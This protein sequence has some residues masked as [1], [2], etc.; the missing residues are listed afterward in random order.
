[1]KDLILTLKKTVPKHT[2][3]EKFNWC[4][5]DWLPYSSDFKRIRDKMS[6]KLDKCHWCKKRFELD[7]MISLAQPQKGPNR[8]L[9]SNCADTMVRGGI[10]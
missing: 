9:C 5:K 10:E 3:I 1:M 2:H 8:V 6:R 4:R 7:E